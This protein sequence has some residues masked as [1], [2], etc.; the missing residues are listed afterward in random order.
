MSAL[1]ARLRAIVRDLTQA[2]IPPE[3][4]VRFSTLPGWDSVTH[5]HLLLDVERTFDLEIPDAV[6]M[7]LDS[8][9]RLHDYIAAQ[10]S[11]QAGGGG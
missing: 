8:I 10:R 3:G 2:T 1:D 6:G 9:G 5:L 11:G 4:D 7:S